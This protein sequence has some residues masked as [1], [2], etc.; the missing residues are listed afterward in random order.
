M[1]PRIKGVFRNAIWI[2]QQRG[3]E[4]ADQADHHAAE[5]DVLGRRVVSVKLIFVSK[6]AADSI[7]FSSEEND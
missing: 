7:Q 5:T 4:R 6:I 2:G 1:D 3:S